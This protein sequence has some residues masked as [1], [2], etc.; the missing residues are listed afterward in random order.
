MDQ[1]ICTRTCLFA[2]EE[3]VN[4]CEDSG[5]WK[6]EALFLCLLFF[7]SVHGMLEVWDLLPA[8]QATMSK[9]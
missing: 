7:V 6:T 3:S 5:I 1:W 2:L 8:E 9:L 4:L